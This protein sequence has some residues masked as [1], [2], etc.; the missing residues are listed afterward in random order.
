MTR[1][2]LTVSRDRP[3]AYRSIGEALRDATNG[4]LITVAGGT[5]E[6][7]LVVTRMV[8][9]AAMNGAGSVLIK[10]DSRSAVV[11]DAEAVQLSGLTVS[12]GDGDTAAVDIRRGEAALDACRITGPGWT[13]ILA[14]HQGTLVARDCRID[15]AQG[16]GIVV[17]S[18]GT[19]TVEKT[20]VTGTVSSAIVV[21]ESGRLT[22]R[23]S[24]V[25]QAGGNGI[26]VNGHG[27]AQIKDTAITGSDK[28]ALVVEQ[29]GAATVEGLTVTD[30]VSVDAYLTSRGEISLTDCR[31]SGTGADSVHIAGGS[32]PLLRGCTVAAPTGAALRITEKSRPGL[33]NCRITHAAV[34][35][36][37]DAESAPSLSQVTVREAAQTGVLVT[38]G[39][40]AEF[41]QLNVA[42][43]AGGGLRV[44]GAAT[45]VLRDCEI[46]TDK[47]SAVELAEKGTGTFEG[48]RLRTAGG[49]GF[50]LADGARAEVVSA[51]L[52]G[53]EV[54]V[55][56][57]AVLA[58][59]DSEIAGSGTDGV[60]VTAGGSLTAVGC[61]VHSARG[62]GVNI[63]VS[64][65][66]EVSNC[67]IF[68]NAGD[69]VRTNTEEPV[70]VRDCEV[71]DNGGRQVHQLRDNPQ[72]QAI[73]LTGVDRQDR[74]RRSAPKGQ[75]WPERGDEPEPSETAQHIGTGPLAEL[76]ALVGL[77][78]VKQ[79]VTGL[80][81]LN[82]MA[83][84]REEMG[85]PMPP[86]S[87]HLVF[88]GPPGTGKTTVARL[89]GAVLAE[90]GILAKGHIMEVA[91]ADLVAQYIGATAIKTTEVFTKAI[92]G[93]LF[94]DEAYTLTSQSK[95]SGPDFGQEAVESL[96]KLMEDHR[97][98]VVVIVAGYSE[99]MD[100]FLSSNPGMA[101]RFSRT[102]EF[103]N[104]TVDELV[105]IVRGLCSKHYYELTDSAL[106]ALTSYF[107]RTPKGPTFGNGRVAR[108]LFESMINRQASRLAAH[109]PGSDSALSRLEAEDVEPMAGPEPAA[110]GPEGG[111]Q[112]EARSIRR[113]RNLVGLDAVQESLLGRIAGLADL[114]RQR[115]PIAGL[116][117]LV[118]AGKEGSG[119]RAVARLY[120]RC[121]AETGLL[122]T[123]A[124]Q[125]QALSAFPASWREQADTFG[126][127]LFQEAAGGLLLLEADQ[128]FLT[129][130]DA[131]RSAVLGALRRAADGNAEVALALLGEQPLLAELLN[132]HSGSELAACFAE[133][134]Q[135]PDYT[136]EQLAELAL[137]HLA[138]RGYAVDD[139]V[140][141]SLAEHFADSPPPA[142]AYGAHRFAERLAAADSPAIRPAAR[143]D[144]APPEEEEAGQAP[145]EE[146][147]PALAGAGAGA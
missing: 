135:F 86:M 100:Q 37:V 142:G 20:V 122:A 108:Q 75:E 30:S 124:L 94:I 9:I 58:L 36:L 7:A 15:D 52:H 72:F 103:P 59:R 98:Q 85:L 89:Y 42:E 54:L 84:R 62:N 145:P 1:Q 114:H 87:R 133:F 131:E 70:V 93:V 137:R 67:A 14:W 92:G 107:E 68:D 50:S 99:Q 45:V 118:F 77:D 34:G 139:H 41:E 11:I 17:T 95:G 35:V 4:A 83:Q 140:R 40:A 47:A 120:A 141:N 69:G 57:D 117:N 65:R 138:V 144:S 44:A 113:L 2:V 46:A 56:T 24:V 146:D 48:L 16:A 71:R 101:S 64:A 90:L 119:R 55:G 6:E 25:D 102:V 43:G 23:D 29:N 38:G 27:R 91:R 129:R 115:Q 134:V 66:G 81:N 31:F 12:G 19:N 13:A 130:P 82:K 79:E 97:D 132:A 126:M 110:S 76:E 127:A 147:S 60:R 63:Q 74:P 104:Y 18:S 26:C 49:S 32:S 21:A 125:Q 73:N 116:M 51:A 105:T 78:S 128:A 53:C 136:G 121:L 96:M 33:E 112:P 22:V 88:A 3:G 123:G 5:Y 28:P 111:R 10:S 61:R 106:D 39:A 143:P 8:T 109:P 80:I